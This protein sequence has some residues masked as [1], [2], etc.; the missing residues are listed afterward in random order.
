MRRQDFTEWRTPDELAEYVRGT[1]EFI[2][3]NEQLKKPARLG[4]E[5][6]KTFVKELMPFSRFC[7]CKYGHREDVRCALSRLP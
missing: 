5:P 3:A 4:R 2:A 7:S 6:Y 1:Y